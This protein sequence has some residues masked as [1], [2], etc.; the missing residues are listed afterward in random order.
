M[1]KV[2]CLL[3]LLTTPA[4]A[5]AQAARG[6]DAQPPGLTLAEPKWDDIHVSFTG[7]GSFETSSPG[8]RV[9]P[10][11]NNNRPWQHVPRYIP[12]SH[13]SWSPNSNLRFGGSNFFRAASVSLTN[14]GAHNVKAVRLEFVFTDPATGAEVLRLRHR[15][16]KKL[17]PGFSKLIRKEVRAS[18]RIRRADGALLSVE[19]T[20]VVYSDGTSWRR[21]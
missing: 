4:A 8:P 7:F 10:S 14:T 16:T 21:S 12:Q 17:K 19:V 2:L 3:M 5:S 1:K 18:R 11:I 15:T 13:L 6:A 9:H 20:E